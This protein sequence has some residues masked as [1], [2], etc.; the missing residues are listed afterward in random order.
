M[1]GWALLLFGLCL[2][3]NIVVEKMSWSKDAHFMVTRKERE[4]GGRKRERERSWKQDRVPI[5]ACLQRPI[6]CN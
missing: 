4:V 2:G 3:E 1:V 6:L 5:R